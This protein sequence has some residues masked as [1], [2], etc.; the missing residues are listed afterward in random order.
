MFKKIL[1]KVRENLVFS[2]IS[3]I[4]IGLI[5][6]S[7]F[8]RSIPSDS[9][10][11]T[12]KGRT[13]KTDWLKLRSRFENDEKYKMAEKVYHNRDYDES[14]NA[15]IN[16]INSN[17]LNHFEKFYVLYNLYDTKFLE[18]FD[19]T[20]SNML[21]LSTDTMV[22]ADARS[23]ALSNS[24]LKLHIYDMR[25]SFYDRLLNEPIYHT[26]LLGRKDKFD[27]NFA[28]SEMAYNTFPLFESSVFYLRYLQYY[29]TGKSER[30]MNFEHKQEGILSAIYKNL[31]SYIKIAGPD[32]KLEHKD[33]FYYLSAYALE[34]I[35]AE[36]EFGYVPVDEEYD[37]ETVH[38]KMD[39]LVAGRTGDVYYCN[40]FYYQIY[41]YL[42]VKDEASAKKY[43]EKLSTCPLLQSRV[44]Y[45]KTIPLFNQNK[46][47]FVFR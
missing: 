3:F 44:E 30:D 1:D 25:D 47:V 7:L 22:T 8:Y 20:F 33:W 26:Y 4:I 35:R 14:V 45:M 11:L 17:D 38:K 39:E 34:E 32:I 16:Y 43:M 12:T 5:V 21:S 37:F 40:Y 24:I 42:T 9:D 41:Y 18:K 13:T 6:F 28:L 23:L 29:N 27:I 15:T 2:T 36:K 46:D 19:D 10:Y 31:D